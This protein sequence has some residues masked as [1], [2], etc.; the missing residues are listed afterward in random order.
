MELSKKNIIDL[1]DQVK[2]EESQE[3]KIAESI[4]AISLEGNKLSLD[5]IVNNPAL[6]FKE[7]VKSKICTHLIHFFSELDIEV[8]FSV[9]K[10]NPC[11]FTNSNVPNDAVP[12][13]EPLIFPSTLNSEPPM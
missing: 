3:K 12:V 10:T 2:L 13:V 7:K 4:K 1:L 11:E 9:D 5:I 8:K 6:Q